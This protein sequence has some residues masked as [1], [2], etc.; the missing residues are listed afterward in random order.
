M[1]TA[2]DTQSDLFAWA[3]DLERE[4]ER[5]AEINA[6]RV[7]NRGYLVFATDPNDYRRARREWRLAPNCSSV[8]MASQGLSSAEIFAASISAM[9]ARISAAASRTSAGVNLSFSASAIYGC[10][11]A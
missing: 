2:T 11:Q 3:K 8:G 9:K 10:S 5:I 6:Q 1:T 4:N 7:R